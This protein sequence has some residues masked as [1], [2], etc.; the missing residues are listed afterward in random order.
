[1]GIL[2]AT[3]VTQLCCCLSRRITRP[4]SVAI[5]IECCYQNTGIAMA[6]AISMFAD[7][8]QRRTE[9]LAVALWY[10]LVEAIVIGVFCVCAWRLNWTKAPSSDSICQVITNEYENVKNDA[11]N[12]VV[13][14]NGS[15]ADNDDESS[16]QESEAAFSNQDYGSVEEPKKAPIDDSYKCDD[17][18]EQ[19]KE[20][21]PLSLRARE[22]PSETQAATPSPNKPQLASTVKIDR[23]ESGIDGYEVTIGDR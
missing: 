8:A 22:C 23:S 9:A 4:E 21:A 3:T 19:A 13:D 20:E 1:M 2:L 6:T 11:D 10:S 5:S 12:G 18:E 15:D 14:N 17:D 7:D 16:Q